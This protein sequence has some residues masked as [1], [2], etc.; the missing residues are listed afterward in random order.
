MAANTQIDADG[1]RPGGRSW[2]RSAAWGAAAMLLL[3]PLLAMQFT[4]EVRWDAA[5]F[6]LFG[7]MLLI[8]GG[9]F[10]L[11][12]RATRRKRYRIAWGLSI[13][14]VFVLLWLDAAVGIVGS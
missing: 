12:V 9:A 6:A 14:V 7:A 2:W 8:A 4:E 1:G 3:L 10:E 13:A 5:D 11:V